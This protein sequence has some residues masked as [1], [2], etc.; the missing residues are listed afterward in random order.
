MSEQSNQPD[1]L[2]LVGGRINLID[3]NAVVGADDDEGIMELEEAII[4]GDGKRKMNGREKK[5]QLIPLL[6]KRGIGTRMRNFE[7]DG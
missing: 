5:R 6:Q 7:D 3:A 1:V 4:V 2:E